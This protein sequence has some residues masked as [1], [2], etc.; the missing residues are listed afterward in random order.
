MK[1]LLV[2]FLNFCFFANTYSQGITLLYTGANGPSFSDSANWV[3]IDV[4]P[5]QPPEHR[6]PTYIDDV[7]FSKTQ[8]GLTSVS[9]LVNGT[10]TL[11]IGG[12]SSSFCRRMYVRGLDI[13]FESTFP[14]AGGTVFVYTEN[15]G[16]LSLDSGAVLRHGIV[17]STGGN[18]EVAGLQVTDSK[19]GTY[20]QHNADWADVFLEDDGQAVF[21]R[22]TFDGFFFGSA[23]R[24]DGS[25]AKGGGLY[26]ENSVFS[27][28]GFILGDN[29]INTFLNSSIRPVANNYDLKFLIGRNASFVS[30]NDTIHVQFG[31]LD[32]TTSG[33]I[34]K[35]TVSGWYFNFRQEDPDNPLPNIIDGDVVM[36][37]DPGAGI[38]GDVKVSG[39]FTNYMPP[40]GFYPVPVEVN[41]QHAFDIGGIKNFGGLLINNCIDDYCHYKLEF[42]GNT[43]SNINWSIGFPIDTLIVNKSACAKVTSTNS[44]YVAG[45]T[46]IVA[47][48]LVLEPN[49]TI[50]YKLVT[51]G[52]IIISPG[53]GLFLKK[54]STGTVANIALAGAITDYN[55]VQDSTCEGLS[56]PYNGNI[57]TYARPLPVTLL[58][59]SGRFYDK[60]ITLDWRTG[61]EHN[62]KH[63]IIEKSYDQISFVFLAKV[64]ASANS[65]G[66]RI[67][68]Y[69]D[70][71]LL[72][73]VNYYRLKR[74][75]ADGRFAYS[76]IIAIAA[77]DDRTFSLYPN[78]VN[79]KLTIHMP[80]AFGPAEIS[81]VDMKG[82]CVRNIKLTAG[83]KELLLT[84]A[85]LPVGVYTIVL[86]STTFKKT[87]RFVKE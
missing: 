87:L 63:F 58:D 47:G 22:S 3:Q 31:T 24:G 45:Q 32:F 34:F 84:T 29:S 20:T 28:S 7:V 35:G 48:Q 56:N 40:V 19:F 33:S 10:D 62:G 26:S 4:P 77:P 44:L 60:S 86:H 17:H 81:I 64:P 73:E 67:Y 50:P 16:F 76:K 54:D 27:A 70:R 61:N 8:S 51:P 59:F 42:F 36:L 5:G 75:D 15:A 12:D 37:E 68:K 14:D 21:K 9:F 41:G 72:R 13:Y 53:G 2:I 30:E 11:K 23:M 38:S 66:E 83:V 69:I 80:D 79:D 39:N 49:D 65:Q 46:R 43:N 55:T 57:V 6:P 71:T 85:D 74:V 18:P 25:F 82:L 1:Q 78:P 52:D